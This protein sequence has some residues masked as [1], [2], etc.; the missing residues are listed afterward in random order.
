MKTN[1][2]KIHIDD[3][4]QW[5][6]PSS[7]LHHAYPRTVI[8]MEVIYIHVVFRT[9]YLN[10]PAVNGISQPP[11]YI[12]YYRTQNNNSLA[13]HYFVVTCRA[14]PCHAMPCLTVSCRAVPCRAEP[15]HA[16]LCLTVPCPAMLCLTVPCPAMLWRALP[17][18]AVP[19]LAVPCRAVPCPALPCLALP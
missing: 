7:L 4:W 9:S 17:C 19:C 1:K 2:T 18:L 13:Y 10:T 8:P 15:C 16:M 5:W 14:V 12:V 6:F 3:K 11:S